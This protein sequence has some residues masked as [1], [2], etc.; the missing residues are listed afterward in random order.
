MNTR[1][2]CYSYSNG[3]A[4]AL[5]SDMSSE[6]PLINI[7]QTTVNSTAAKSTNAKSNIVKSTDPK[8]AAMNLL[9]I[10]SPL[11]YMFKR[12]NNAKT[13]RPK[14][15]KRY[16]GSSSNPKTPAC[17]D[18]DDDYN[19]RKYTPVPD[20]QLVANG[21]NVT[22]ARAFEKISHS[23]TD[24]VNGVGGYVSESALRYQRAQKYVAITDEDL[25]ARRLKAR[26]LVDEGKKALGLPQHLRDVLF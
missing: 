14:R 17:D 16:R 2:W 7:E 12:D 23:F 10:L 20:Y 18:R 4:P 1:D 8:S 6:E 11:K 13:Y 21:L 15:T 26:K 3:V 22:R 19:I 24:Y 5:Q 9:S 25:H